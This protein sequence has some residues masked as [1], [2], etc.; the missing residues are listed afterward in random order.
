MWNFNVLNNCDSPISHLPG[1]G[2]FDIRNSQNM[3]P[4]VTEA[5]SDS[6]CF[7]KKITTK[8]LLCGYFLTSVTLCST[9]WNRIVKDVINNNIR[10]YAGGDAPALSSFVGGAE[11]RHDN[12]VMTVT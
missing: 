4:S 2:C 7:A 11:D 8:H 9:N 5:A 3:S 10:K 1:L 6:S 12:N